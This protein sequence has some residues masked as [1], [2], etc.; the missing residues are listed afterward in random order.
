MNILDIIKNGESNTVEF[1]SWKKS[2]NFK[3]LI[4]LLVKEAVGFANTKGG[5]ILVGVEDN[6]DITGCDNFDTQNI[7]ESIYDKTVPNLF[8][9]IEV[10]KIEDKKILVITVEKNI[11]KVST[12]KGVSYRR[13]GKNTKPDYPMEYSSNRINGFRGDYSSKIIEPSNKNDIELHCKMKCNS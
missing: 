8:S 1:K 3:D 9:D 6:G 10:E 4:E 7:I 5:T 2:S 11:N 12:S 13:L